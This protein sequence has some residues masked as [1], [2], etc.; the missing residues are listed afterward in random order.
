MLSGAGSSVAWEQQCL[1]GSY[2]SSALDGICKLE[3]TKYLTFLCLRL[4]VKLGREETCF[5]RL[6]HVGNTLGVNKAIVLKS[7]GAYL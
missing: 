6:H 5:T 3:Q 1:S 4:S 2:P 7:V